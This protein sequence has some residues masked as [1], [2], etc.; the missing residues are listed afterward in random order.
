MACSTMKNKQQWGGKQEGRL[1]QSG[2]TA[3]VLVS[4]TS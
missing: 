3:K 1:L 2:I 4:F